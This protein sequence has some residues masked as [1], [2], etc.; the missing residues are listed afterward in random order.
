VETRA[1]LGRQQH[2][3]AGGVALSC[4]AHKSV[5][6][7]LRVV[8][9]PLRIWRVAKALGAIHARQK[10]HVQPRHSAHT[11]AAEEEEALGHRAALARGPLAQLRAQLLFAAADAVGRQRRAPLAA[12]HG[13][14]GRRVVAPHVRAH[15]EERC[16]DA[17]VSAP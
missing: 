11:S 14:Q 1:P 13:L 15:A 7:A 5:H 4:D 6:V 9:R 17:R 16:T 2:V 12:Q 10:R 3:D 8:R